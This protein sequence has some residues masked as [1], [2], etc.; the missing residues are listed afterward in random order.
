M[1]KGLENE[2]KGLRVFNFEEER[3]NDLVDSG[4]IVV[5]AIR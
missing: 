5:S 1:E 2:F 4:E 3:V